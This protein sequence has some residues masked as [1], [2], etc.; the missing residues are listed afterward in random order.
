MEQARYVRTYRGSSLSPTVF[1]QL[2][3]RFPDYDMGQPVGI[4]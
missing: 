3:T 1:R 2:P 4:I